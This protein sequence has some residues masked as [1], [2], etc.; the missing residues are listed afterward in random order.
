M[1]SLYVI[2]PFWNI[3][4]QFDVLVICCSLIVTK[5]IIINSSLH[6]NTIY[7]IKYYHTKNDR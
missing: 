4:K 6:E 7:V 3:N 5:K 1:S 2:L